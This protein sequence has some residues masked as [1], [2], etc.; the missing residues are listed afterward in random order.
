MLAQEDVARSTFC[1]QMWR[2]PCGIRNIWTCQRTSATCATPYGQSVKH[3]MHLELT[4]YIGVNER[5]CVYACDAL[6]AQQVKIPLYVKHDW[7]EGVCVLAYWCI[8]VVWITALSATWR[9]RSLETMNRSFACVVRCSGLCNYAHFDLEVYRKK[10]TMSNRPWK[11][12]KRSVKNLK[13]STPV[14]SPRRAEGTKKEKIVARKRF[15]QKC[16]K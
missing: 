12:P 13:N 1:K 16:S 8:G 11:I 7:R 15:V 2:S 6:Q 14:R 5:V 9:I 3:L 4:G 10:I